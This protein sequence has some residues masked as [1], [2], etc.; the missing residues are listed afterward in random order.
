MIEDSQ[1][2]KAARRLD[3]ELRRQGFVFDRDE[4]LFRVSE[5]CTFFAFLCDRRLP[6]CSRMALAPRRAG[7]VCEPR[8][9]L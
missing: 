3:S 1:L 8:V 4:D 6:I 9:G 2:E 7:G 5:K